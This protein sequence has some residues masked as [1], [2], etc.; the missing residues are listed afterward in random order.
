MKRINLL[1]IAF[2]VSS[3]AIGVFSQ[4]SIQTPEAASFEPFDA[5]NMVDLMTG[6]FSYSI[7]L[8]VVPSGNNG[9][10]INI[11]Y[12]AG[13]QEYAEASWVGLGWNINTGAINRFVNSVPDDWNGKLMGTTMHVDGFEQK[14]NNLDLKIY[15]LGVGKTWGYNKSYYNYESFYQYNVSFSKKGV[16]VG[17]SWGSRGIGGNL[18]MNLS[19]FSDEE[20][21]R[22]TD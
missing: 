18:S 15:G 10:P 8:L 9:Y 11:F 3:C 17:I 13:V 20:V 14:T 5:A 19:K 4:T 2:I 16:G 7:P 22:A 1:G 21:S 12:H 6:D